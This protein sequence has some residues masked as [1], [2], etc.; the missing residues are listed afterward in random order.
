MNLRLDEDLHA[1]ETNKEVEYVSEGLRKGMSEWMGR[2]RKEGRL[3][4]EE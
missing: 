1:R 3:E 4:K 2:G